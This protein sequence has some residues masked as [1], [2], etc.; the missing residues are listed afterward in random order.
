MPTEPAA[1]ATPAALQDVTRRRVVLDTDL[2]SDPDDAMALAVLL[3]SD[4]VDLLGASTVYGDVE[5][6]ARLLAGYAGLAGASVTVATGVAEPLS[7]KPVW[8]SGEE[9]RYF[10]GVPDLDAAGVVSDGLGWLLDRSRESAGDLDLLAIGPLTNLAAALR[11]EP[12]FA[13]GVRRVWMMGGL[14]AAP[15]AEPGSDDPEHNFS[16]DAVAASEV[17]ASGLPITVLGLELTRRLRLGE[18]ELAALLR[19]GKL[20][21]QLEKET[22]A[23]MRYW[24]EPFDV[25]H[26]AIAA[27]AMLRPDLFTVR[28]ARVRVLPQGPR[29]GQVVEDDAGTPLDIVTDLDRPAVTR[30]ILERIRVAATM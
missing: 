29:A 15:G 26:D 9:G 21:A 20:G 19:M 8:V 7:G 6:R 13:R 27:V 24:D 5:L 22:R 3:G 14:F 28:T 16:S 23:W 17:L 1:P 18:P 25:P 11:A 12:S 30:E 2:G 10:P 4:E